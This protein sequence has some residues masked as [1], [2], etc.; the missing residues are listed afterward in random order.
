MDI[1]QA[2]GIRPSIADILLPFWRSSEKYVALLIL[3]VIIGITFFMAWVHVVSNRL[4]G[5][6]TDALIALNWDSI[7]PLFVMSFLIGTLAVLIP[8]FSVLLNQYLAL[9]WR[10]WLTT[11]YLRDWTDKAVFYQIER[12]DLIS[13]ADQRIAEDVR[14]LVETSLNF[15]INL[16]SVVVNIVTYT[17]LLWQVAGVLRFTFQGTQWVIPGYLVYTAFIY[18]ILQLV[19]SHWLG[20]ALIGLNMHR[21]T[22]EANFRFQAM[23][24]RDNAEQIAFYHGGQQE[25]QRLEG[26]F[27]QVRQNTLHIIFRS[28]KIMVGQSIFSHIFSPIPTL[29]SLPLLLAGHI[30]FGD[31]TRIT[32][33][34]S[35]LSSALSFFM[36]AYQEFTR[37]LAL[38]NRL[39]DLHWAIGKACG[40]S[41]GIRYS[42]SGSEPLSCRDLR[43]DSPAK[44]TLNHI[45]CWRIEPGE[46]W[47]VRGPSGVGKSTLLRVCAGLWPYGEGEVALPAREQM[48]F[49]PQ[50]SYIPAG[51]LKVA[52]CYPFAPDD[53][54]D[55]R[56]VQA[57]ND[58]RLQGLSLSLTRSDKWQHTLSG[59]EQQRL[60]LARALLLRPR[61]LFLDEA[62]SALDP[63]T[64][65]HLYEMLLTQ[66]PQTALV[67]VAHRDALADFHNQFLTL[68][69]AAPFAG[70]KS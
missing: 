39:R 69:P 35:A 25:S 37:W 11:R 27:G 19:L 46:R 38:T 3:W 1:Q 63:D 26:R 20:K 13:N 45:P 66:L 54:E 8:Y 67:S 6:F 7:R 51:M 42:A 59:G 2:A 23:Q 61:Y 50:R 9:R 16:V 36:Q 47:L 43:L 64:E 48:L 14:E 15:F 4:A 40:Q 44:R 17:V 68:E 30:T 5:Q 21:Q 41:S 65:R 53:Y 49:L 33:A 18:A 56:C 29:L 22:A 58:A 12:D 32:M 62:T 57:L 55:A 52:L 70:G 60:A 28:F 34:Y 24:L 10:T 31:L